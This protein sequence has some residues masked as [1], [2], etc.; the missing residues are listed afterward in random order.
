MF[1]GRY[2]HTMDGKGR[3]SIPSAFRA[4]LLG[5][6]EGGASAAQAKPPFLTNLQRCV[7]VYPHD[8]WLEVERRLSEAS[9]MQPEVQ[10]LQRFAVSGAIEC[11]IDAQGRILVPPYLREHGALTKD[12]LI[13]GVGP[14]IELWNKER[15]ASDLE[16]T[17]ENL[18]AWAQSFGL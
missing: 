17:Q 4:A 5:R 12:V 16:R 8:A 14:R 9:S 6:E 1:R 15:F 11:P 10:A 13:A 2:T 3:V 7:A 18:S